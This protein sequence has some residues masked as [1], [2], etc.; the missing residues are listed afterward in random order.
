MSFDS[1]QNHQILNH[2]GLILS[3]FILVA[4]KYNKAPLLG[5]IAFFFMHFKSPL[6][7]LSS[8]KFLRHKN[9]PKTAS[10]RFSFYF[11]KPLNKYLGH[12]MENSLQQ[13]SDN[14]F[15]G[16]ILNN[17]SF[18]ITSSVRVDNFYIG[19]PEH[20]THSLNT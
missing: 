3:V 19:S 2:P 14:S 18:K 8:N 13:E 20:V 6:V 11:L 9:P 5:M 10:R 1:T 16:K 15:L 12:K 7:G 17:S 4:I